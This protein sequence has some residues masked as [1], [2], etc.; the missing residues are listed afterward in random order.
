[1]WNHSS[2]SSSQLME[3]LST[4]LVFY[5]PLDEAPAIDALDDGQLD[6]RL[7]SPIKLVVSLDP[8]SKLDRNLFVVIGGQE[9]STKD[10]AAWLPVEALVVQP[11]C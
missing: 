9:I 1:M 6:D 10:V 2:G 4:H 5:D 7:V 11:R 3:V 8:V